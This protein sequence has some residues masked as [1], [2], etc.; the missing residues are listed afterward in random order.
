MTASEN[1]PG[2]W[3]VG[4]GVGTYDDA[5]FGPL[6]RAVA[7]V[8]DIAE[9][10]SQRGYGVRVLCDPDEAGLLTGLKAHLG[11]DVLPAGGPLVVVWAGH[12][13]MVAEQT[14]HLIARD[15]MRG[16]TPE[17][18]AGKIA[19]YAGRTGASQIL[20]VFDTCH[21]Q[22]GALPAFTVADQVLA[23]HPPDARRVWVGVLTSAMRL[24]E[25]ADGRFAAR[26]VRL[27]RQGPQDPELRL[28]WSA[29]SAGV[30]GDDVVDAL[31][32]EWDVGGQTPDASMRGNAWVMLPNPLYDAQAPERVVE[33]LLLAAHG[34]APDEDGVYFTGRAAPLDQIVGWMGREG[35]GVMVVTGPAG[36]GKS[37]LAGRVVSLSNRA[38]RASLL[39]ALGGTRLGHADPGEDSVSAHVHA[40]GLTTQRLVEV[41]GDQLVARGVV[42]RLPGGSRNLGQLWGD[43]QAREV[44]PLLV[45]DGLDEAGLYAFRIA[46]EAVRLLAGVARV[47]VT[48]RDL[49]A[50]GEGQASLVQALAPD[51]VLDLGDASL[52]AATEADV[53]GY[54]ALRLAGTA[55]AGKVADVVVGAA[56]EQGEGMF[57]LA[58]VV[59]SQLRAEPVDTSR[60]GWERLLSRSVEAAFE[61]DLGRVP[62]PRRG[63][64]ELP[65]AAGELLGALAWAYGAGFPDD[66]WPVVATALSPTGTAYD[67]AD[68]FWLLGHAGRYIV[69]AGEGGRAAYRLS[70][71]RLVDH[72]RPPSH[73]SSQNSERQA[74]AVA[75]ALAAVYRTLL[76]AGVPAD[77]PT[78]LWRYLWRHATSG[79]QQGITPLRELADTH[80]VLLPDL[81][82]ALN[83]LG[84]RYAEVGRA[85]DIPQVWQQA[86]DA[87][88]APAAKAFLLTRRAE[89]RP[90]GEQE[91]AIEDLRHALTLIP[92]GEYRLLG[93]CHS[94]CRRLRAA[95]PDTFGWPPPLPPWLVLDQAH[96]DLTWEWTAT[97]TV[98][99]EHEFFRAH[100]DELLA[101]TTAVALEE[102]GLAQGDP[103][104]V[105][106]YRD[107]W[108]RAR[109]DGIDQAY[110]PRL[111]GGLL[112][113]WIDADLD[114]KRA[115]LDEHRQQLLGDDVTETLDLWCAHDPDDDQLLAHQALLT[116]AVAGL[117]DLAFDALAD[118]D[119]FPPLLNTLARAGADPAPI[120]AAATLALLIELP[121][122][123]R[124][125]DPLRV[126]RLE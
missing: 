121:L 35:P 1:P 103:G 113:R 47:L 99:E 122:T 86:I 66:I 101:D 83:N 90:P 17:V 44:C 15:T 105:Q 3:Y 98:A 65:H 33:H 87:L 57:L 56:R 16:A 104:S 10:L 109:R 31:L 125:V 74:A 115:M 119:Q 11:R 38:E 18:T 92:D 41:L 93:D 34:R 30:R 12:G 27:L 37:A 80:P 106:V 4:V 7:D 108:D 67:R 97:T 22:A 26:L 91:A 82:M 75:G 69:E 59:T 48:T 24:E 73:G 58:R 8:E 76:D 94:T 126:Y 81:A 112:A 40:R 89:A 36:C 62:P 114:T 45:V 46:E 60:P 117:A 124:T 28:R 120:H 79:G 102:I 111:A 29:H 88:T 77:E 116:L 53:R 95:A 107:L 84:I 78:Y 2:G 64:A 123:F 42:P 54:V 61:R 71:Q 110:R 52:R 20:L 68:V 50:A 63:D 100:A 14:L 5:H 49:P 118:P 96:L 6:P 21:A 72:L 39:G 13:L 43:L 9:V 32:K 19:S 25:A 23:A 55:D 51:K 85:D 70:H